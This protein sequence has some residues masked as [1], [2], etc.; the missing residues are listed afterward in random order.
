MMDDQGNQLNETEAR[1]A[2]AVVK[3]LSGTRFV[4]PEQHHKHHMWVEAKLEAEE[5]WRNRTGSWVDFIVGGLGLVSIV[6]FVGWFGH[7]LLTAMAEFISRLP[8]AGP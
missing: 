2:E 4:A 8:G 5:R 6:A 7:Y 3:K 1:I